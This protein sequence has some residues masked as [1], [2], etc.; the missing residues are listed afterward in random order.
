MVVFVFA[1]CAC[2]SHNYIFT[3]G[4]SNIETNVSNYYRFG[5]FLLFQKYI[6]SYEPFMLYA[7]TL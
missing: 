4:V 3:I 1:N 6:S 2:I 5:G 7:N